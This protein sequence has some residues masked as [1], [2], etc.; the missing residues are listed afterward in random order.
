M[1]QTTRACFLA[2]CGAALFAAV[3]IN[4]AEKV[5]Q[6]LHPLAD[7]NTVGL[8]LFD[9]RRGC[10]VVNEVEH[11]PKLIAG[12]VFK[13][14][15]APSGRAYIF[16]KNTVRKLSGRK[17]PSF[18]GV[19]TD[20]TK[21]GVR[22]TI[23]AWLKVTAPPPE[24]VGIIYEQFAYKRAGWRL[25][26]RQ[27]LRPLLLVEDRA[28]KAEIGLPGKEKLHV[29]AWVHLAATYDGKELALFLNGN[30]IG[31]KSFVGP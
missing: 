26:I 14:T 13:T 6:Q 30:K 11:G 22:F 29:G 2:F 12:T 9:S 31:V 28:T 23:E 16:G 19:D 7:Q 17:L 10:N 15:A 18:A 25:A 27:D 1:N 3:P 24:T 21:P 4:A 5:S 20:A 8:W